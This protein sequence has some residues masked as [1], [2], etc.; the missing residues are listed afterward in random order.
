MVTD[1]PA[2]KPGAVENST[3]IVE[4]STVTIISDD[5]QT[6]KTQLVESHRLDCALTTA[7][8]SERNIQ[9]DLIELNDS[10][11]A[12]LDSLLLCSIRM[13]LA[14]ESSAG[15]M[16]SDQTRGRLLK[17]KAELESAGVK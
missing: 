9:R 12:K 13:R 3:P 2:G 6:H 17:L 16:L 15:P 7:R 8:H 11:V 1:T 14:A 10:I 4:G 5:L